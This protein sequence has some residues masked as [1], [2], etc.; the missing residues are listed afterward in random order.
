MTPPAYNYMPA[1]FK[2]RR[3]NS[4]SINL[5]ILA[6]RVEPVRVIVKKK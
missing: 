3:F 6:G 2:F 5:L 1:L 4:G